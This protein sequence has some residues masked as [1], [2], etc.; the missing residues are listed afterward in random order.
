ML[1][2]KDLP[3]LKQRA[4]VLETGYSTVPVSEIQEL[5]QKVRSLEADYSLAPASDRQTEMARKPET[6]LE[7]IA[8]LE[9]QGPHGYVGGVPTRTKL[10]KG[11]GGSSVMDAMVSGR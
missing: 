9:G 4:K 11:R 8:D 3:K 10:D 1:D 7:R 6:V 2:D 5:Q